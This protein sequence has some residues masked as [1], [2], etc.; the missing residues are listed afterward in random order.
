[1]PRKYATGANKITPEEFIEHYLQDSTGGEILP[2]KKDELAADI[3]YKAPKGS[4]DDDQLDTPIAKLRAAYQEMQDGSEPPAKKLKG[5]EKASLDIFAKYHK[6][7][8]DDLKDILKWNRQ[9]VTGNKDYL[10][11]KVI[12]GELHGRLP[13]CTLCGG[14][15]KLVEDGVTVSCNGSFDEDAGTKMLCAYRST[16]TDAPRCQPW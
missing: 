10:L 1:M 4:K 13:P 3:A 11:T 12:D 7:K 16:A 6:Q 14:H 2:A 5:I 8:V 9:Y 15:L